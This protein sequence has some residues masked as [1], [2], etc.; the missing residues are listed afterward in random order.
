VKR[1]RDPAD[2]RRQT[3]Q[4]TAAGRKSLERLRRLSQ[5]LEDEFLATLDESE[6]RDLHTLLQRLGDQ[7]LP[8]KG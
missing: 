8:A 4:I 3:V 2:R 5:Q 1:Q 7:H 6:R